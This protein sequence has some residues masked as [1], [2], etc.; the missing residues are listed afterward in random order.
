MSPT[1]DKVHM[2]L[3]VREIIYMG[4]FEREIF[5]WSPYRLTIYTAQT[6]QHTLIYTTIDAEHTSFA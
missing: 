2:I 5:P 1:A 3:I 6:D 4:D